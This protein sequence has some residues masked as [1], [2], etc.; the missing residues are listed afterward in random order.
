MSNLGVSHMNRRAL[1][2]LLACL[3]IV[4]AL[5]TALRYMETRHWLSRLPPQL[6]VEKVVYAETDSWGF[7]PGGNESGVV[8]YELPSHVSGANPS[9]LAPELRWETTPLQGHREWFEGEGASRTDTG[10]LLNNYLNQYGFGIPIKREVVSEIDRAVSVPGSWY[11]YTRNGVI[12]LMP[13]INRVAYIYA[14]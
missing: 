12:L 7:G 3:F 8:V 5:W 14:G 11:A 2:W 6:G 1:G 13:L 9:A 10:P 4:V